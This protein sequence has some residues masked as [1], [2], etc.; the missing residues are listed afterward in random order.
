MAV[1]VRLDVAVVVGLV[2]CV[3]VAVVVTVVSWHS[4]N[5]P[6]WKRRM[7]VLSTGSTVSHAASI[8]RNPVGLHDSVSSSR[9]KTLRDASAMTVRS[10]SLAPAQLDDCTR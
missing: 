9:D 2:V 7:A 4:L 3:D 6:S 5:S 8:L 10:A 1:V